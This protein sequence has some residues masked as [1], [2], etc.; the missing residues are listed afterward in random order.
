VAHVVMMPDRCCCCFLSSRG[1]S[2]PSSQGKSGLLLQDSYSSVTLFQP[3]SPR[4]RWMW[5]TG[6]WALCLMHGTTDVFGLVPEVP[7]PSKRTLLLIS[8]MLQNLANGLCAVC[9]CRVHRSSC[10]LHT[11][12]KF[13]TK[14]A[15][16]APMNA[17]LDQW[18]PRVNEFISSLTV[19]VC[20]GVCVCVCV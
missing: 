17:W 16:L 1:R 2:G 8:K 6:V 5:S 15:Y 3:W 11:G 9:S 13:G 18:S 12:T 4:V 14:E 20:D 7:T 10:P 19:C